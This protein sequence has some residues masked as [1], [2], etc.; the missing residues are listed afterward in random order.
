MLQIGAKAPE[1]ELYDQNDNLFRLTEQT[2]KRVI[3]YFYSKDNTSGCTKQAIAFAGA[4]EQIKALGAVLVGISK[5]TVQ[6]HR[7]FAEKNQLPFTLLADPEHRALEDY[8]V[9]Q[10]KTQC[11]KKVMGTV[12]AT[13]VIGPDGTVEHVWPKVKP[14]ANA[15]DVVEYL[16]K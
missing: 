11:G 8:E 3:V 13:Y 2:G 14:E 10:E 16:S 4:F 15:A 5:D 1:I 12:R 9:W 7:K 6:S